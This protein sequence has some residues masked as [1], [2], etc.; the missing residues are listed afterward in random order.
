VHVPYPGGYHVVEL[1]FRRVPLPGAVVTHDRVGAPA[2][3]RAEK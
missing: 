2:A 1:R 3:A